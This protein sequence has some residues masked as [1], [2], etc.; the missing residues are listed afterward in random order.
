MDVSPYRKKNLP[1]YLPVALIVILTGTML[2]AGCTSLPSSGTS[3]PAVPSSLV[4]IA[5]ILKNPSA[6]NG[7]VVA[8]QGKINAECGSGCWFMM[9]DGTATLYVDLA[10]NNFAI[11][12]IQGTKVV[13]EGTISVIK[14]DPTLVA[15][16]VVTDSRTWP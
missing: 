15:T 7:T 16:K 9:D 11:P 3:S 12:Q 5:D 2:I 6:Y 1:A 13:V 4:R 14:G 10:P 8:V